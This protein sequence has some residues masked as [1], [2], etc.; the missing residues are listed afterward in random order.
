MR[1]HISHFAVGAFFW[2]LLLVAGQGV[3]PAQSPRD[4]EA[5]SEAKTQAQPEQET[6]SK[7][8]PSEPAFRSEIEVGVRWI[9][10]VNG[11]YDTYRS[12]VNLGEGPRLTAWDMR[13]DPPGLGFLKRAE[14]QGAGWGGDPASW[15]R[16]RAE[17]PRSYRFTADHRSTAYF[18]AMPSFANP[19]LARG[20]LA[21]QRSF[22][23]ARR[24]TELQLDLLPTSVIIP[25]VSFV[26]DHGFGRGVTGFVSDANEYPVVNELDDAANLYRGGVRLERRNFHMFFEQGGIQFRDNQRLFNN[27]RHTGNLA[28]PLFGRTLFL[29]DLLQ[30]YRVRGSSIFTRGALNAQPASWVDLSGA[31]QFSQPRNDVDYR[32]TNT[33][34]FIDLDSLLFL[35][36]QNIRLLG[37]SKQP[38]MT[39]NLGADLRLGARL[40]WMQSWMTDRLHNATALRDTPVV[41]RLHWNYSQQ[42]S[43][44]LIDLTRFLTL[45]GGYRYVWGDGLG[46]S[47]LL[48]R[49]P[50]ESGELRRHVALAGAALRLASSVSLNWDAEIARSDR[51]LYRTSLTDYERFRLRARYQARPSLLVYGA[52]HYL[53][54]QNP[55][56]FNAFEFRN[57]Q[58]AVGIQW[59]PGAKRLQLLGE[60]SRSTIRSNLE[61]LTP[62]ML[63]FRER[64]FYRENAHTVTALVSVAPPSSWSWRPRL[65]LGGSAFL[66]SGSR[67]TEFYQPVVRLT[68]PVV[69]HVELFSEYRWW[70]VAQTFYAYEGFRTHQGLVGLRI[71]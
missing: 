22:D 7:G 68:A 30:A 6:K 51:V 58:T 2:P 31:F 32:Q 52:W 5:T 19:Q 42:Q 24:F 67:P 57:Q 47:G 10:A 33:G 46:R 45:R 8:T 48:G 44:L 11:H 69:K 62:Q 66:S 35:S 40:R 54:N 18:N 64:S 61:Y 36:A 56:R 50:F 34:L 29:D 1:R 65:S 41:D 71:Y 16:F 4:P 14:F 39:A 20:I 17:E 55:P 70:G 27:G 60:Y 13:Y 25:Y 43:E 12:I 26:R 38:H 23:I 15:L 49:T 28:Q 63:S 37:A 59:L 21:N 3:Q 9:Q 53:D